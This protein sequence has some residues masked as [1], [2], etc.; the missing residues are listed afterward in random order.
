MSRQQGVDRI[1]NNNA[2]DSGNGREDLR[3][4]FADLNNRALALKDD[5]IRFNEA[6]RADPQNQI[7]HFGF[8][9]N[10]FCGVFDSLQ[11]EYFSDNVTYCVCDNPMP[12][13]NNYCDPKRKLDFLL[14]EILRLIGE[15]CFYYTDERSGN[16]RKRELRQGIEALPTIKISKNH[17]SEVIMCAICLSDFEVAEEACHLRCNENHIFHRK[18]VQR[19]LKRQNQCPIC[20]TSAY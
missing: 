14:S 11:A 3:R 18:C 7:N 15:S 2:G 10:L 17:L 6:F 1:V 12:G 9:I 4:Y 16:R 13:C 19:W 20:R 5:V 8:H